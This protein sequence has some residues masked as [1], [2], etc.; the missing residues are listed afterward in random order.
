M[1]LLG[2]PGEERGV[3]EDFAI[4]GAFAILFGGLA[5]K[6]IDHFVHGFPWQ[7]E[8]QPAPLSDGL[9]EC[10]LCGIITVDS[11]G[12]TRRVGTV[13]TCWIC[14]RSLVERAKRVA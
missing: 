13:T 1:P 3:V 9:S 8:E 4:V 10:E 2:E 12:Q 6:M 14:Y 11:C 5:L 7:P